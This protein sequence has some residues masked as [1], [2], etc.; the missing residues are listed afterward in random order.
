MVATVDKYQGEQNDYIILSLVRTRSIGYLR[1]I[2]RLTVALSRAR[3]GLYILG[4]RAVF[5]SV[6]ELKPAFDLL[7]QRPTQLALITGEMFGHTERRAEAAQAEQQGEAVMAGVEH[8]GQYVFDMS[9]AKLQAL[10]SDDP[11]APGAVALPAV[12]APFEVQVPLREVRMLDAGV[13]DDRDDDDRPENV[14]VP[15]ALQSVVGET[16]KGEL[17][18]Q[19]DL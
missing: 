15:A 11:S 17:E 14:L 18:Q 4:R 16:S 2:R 9:K 3:L 5:E 6:F 12:L 1:D 19:E 13:D 7:F 8:L 10:A